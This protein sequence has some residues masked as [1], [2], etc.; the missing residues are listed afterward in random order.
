MS[1]MYLGLGSNVDPERN[2]RLA[3]AE[4]RSLYGELDVSAVYR[5]KAFGFDGADF[6]NL[7][8]GCETGT[9]PAAVNDQIER[10]HA[11]AGRIRGEARFADRPLDIDLLLYDD[12][13][14]DEPGMQLPRTD[15]L[16]YNFVLRPLAEIAPGVKHPLTGKTLAEHWREFDDMEQPLERVELEL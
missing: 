11:L 7:V 8:V 9:G 6:L 1:R 2:L 12:L 16:D 5:S 10:I 14:I 3:M 13:V 4:L 15:V